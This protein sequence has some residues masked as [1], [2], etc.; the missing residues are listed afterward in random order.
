MVGKVV[1]GRGGGDLVGVG[2][3]GGENYCVA[4]VIVGLS[5]CDEVSVPR[6]VGLHRMYSTLNMRTMMM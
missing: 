3:V 5:C 2:W 1:A 4:Y 6:V